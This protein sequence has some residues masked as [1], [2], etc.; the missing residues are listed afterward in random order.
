MSD[1]S[2]Y[3]KTEEEMVFEE[4]SSIFKISKI[5]SH[6]YMEDKDMFIFQCEI[7]DYNP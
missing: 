3:D 5:I 4:G 2:Q 1:G 7:C 6:K